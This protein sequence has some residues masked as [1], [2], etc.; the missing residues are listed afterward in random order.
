VILADEGQKGALFV[1]EGE[2]KG[3]QDICKAGSPVYLATRLAMVAFSLVLFILV[4]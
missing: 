1:V 3:D 2:K 4:S